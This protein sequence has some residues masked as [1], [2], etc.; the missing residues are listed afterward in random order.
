LF[1]T[2][3]NAKK[4]LKRF[5]CYSQSR[6]VGAVYGLARKQRIQTVIC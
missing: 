4:A 5:S 2:Q 1:Q 6:S 3:T